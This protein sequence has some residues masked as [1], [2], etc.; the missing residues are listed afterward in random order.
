MT[1]V[2]ICKIDGCSKPTRSRGWCNVHYQ[3]FMRLGNALAECRSKAGNGSLLRFLRDVVDNP[4]E[5]CVPWPFTKTR[6]GYGLV[7]YSGR[8]TTAH[9][10]AW[11]MFHGRKMRDGMQAAHAPVI[12]HTRDC[13]N[14]LHIREASPSDNLAD[15]VNDGTHNRGS[16]Q[17]QSKLT[18]SQVDSIRRDP[19][20]HH[21][22]AAD[23]GVARGT[24]SG[25]KS[26]KRWA[27]L[28]AA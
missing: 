5:C 28:N 10:A 15:K 8:R 4:P 14:P 3:R 23:Y 26:G 21:E 6:G 7:T 13:V 11:E 18:A 19:R 2:H 24:V 20:R 9:R 17:W 12:C 1:E 27:W 16:R 22:I 25:I